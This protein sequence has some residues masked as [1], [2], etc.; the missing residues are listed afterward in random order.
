MIT[1]DC[2][3]NFLSSELNAKER[4]S[5]ECFQKN[6]GRTKIASSYRSIPQFSAQ[7]SYIQFLAQINNAYQQVFHFVAWRKVGMQ[8]V[9][10]AYMQKGLQAAYN[11]YA[12]LPHEE[13]GYNDPSWLSRA[14]AALKAS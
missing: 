12:A 7:M 11:T 10:E 13:D 6:K 9:Y 3:A 2:K 1:L 14:Q 8:I 4:S 5:I